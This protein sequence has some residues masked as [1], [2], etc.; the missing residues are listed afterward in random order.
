MI[1]LDKKIID[2]ATIPNS[3]ADRYWHYEGFT[4]IYKAF[5]KGVTMPKDLINVN[6]AVKVQEAYNYGG[7][8]FGNWLNNE[9]RYNYMSALY[10]AS[11]D[12]NKIMKL[13]KNIGFDKALSV[14]FGS[15]GAGRAIAH[16]EPGTNVINITR[17]KEGETFIG[18]GGIGS[19]AHEYG[20]FIDY[21]IGRYYDRSKYFS[22]MSGGSI[23]ATKRIESNSAGTM[24]S[25]VE[26]IIQ[27]A[28]W[29]E[30]YTKPSEFMNRINAFSTKAYYRQRDEIF[31][32]LF[33]Q[34]IG[35]KLHKINIYNKFLCETKYTPKIYMNQ[36]ELNQV[37]PLFDKL[38]IEIRK[39]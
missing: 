3:K 7:F 1:G 26:D 12:L 11:Y 2:T 27:L 16:Y 24:R 25:I 18:S 21:Y 19:F 8:Q 30:P 28:M 35:Y 39:L 29:K 22:A 9:D 31:A 38:L 17:Y 20:H 15:R 23:T 4:P 36:K 14:S 5:R 33:E 10:I 37:V 34:Y 32:R 13:D 6:N